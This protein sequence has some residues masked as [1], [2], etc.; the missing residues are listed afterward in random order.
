MDRLQNWT[1][2]VISEQTEGGK[3]REREGWRPKPDASH[4]RS[5][6]MTV[7]STCP[8]HL[9]LSLSNFSTAVNRRESTTS[10]YD[11]I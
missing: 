8:F 9:Y 10:T 5:F 2:L 7:P 3:P 6:Y 11:G 1:D 4:D